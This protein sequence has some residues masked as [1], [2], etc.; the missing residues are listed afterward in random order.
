MLITAESTVADIA[1]HAP[2]TITVFQRHHIDFCCGGKSPLADVCAERHI[3]TDALVAELEAVA[4]PQNDGPSWADATLTALVA[5]IQRRYHE[6]LRQEL[7]RLDAM[8]E[9]VVSR[10]GHHL[11]EVLLPLQETFLFL[12]RDLLDHMQ[13]EDVVL[14]PLIVSLESRQPLSDPQAA[15]W[16]GAPIAAMEAEHNQA[17]GALQ[18]MRELT[19]GYAPPDWACPT[20][21]GLYYGLA[22]LEADM[23]VHVHLENHILF[24]RAAQLATQL[25]G[26]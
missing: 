9:K 4:M 10:H 6:H 16:I 21:R 24:P 12:Q 1:T 19:G 17:G 25:T 3:D 15:K 5:H 20:F 8:L 7:P 11:P 18:T 23:H 14:F 26:A 2:A 22:Q 13:R